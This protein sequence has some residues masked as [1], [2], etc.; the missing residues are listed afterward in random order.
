[1]KL[2]AI[3]LIILI[4][5]PPATQ[6]QSVAPA[7]F[8]ADTAAS[9][10]W[11]A[12]D[13]TE[14]D[15]CC[16]GWSSSFFKGVGG[17][18]YWTDHL[19]TELDISWPGTTR[20]FTYSSRPNTAESPFIYDDHTYTT[21]KVSASQ[22]YQFGQNAVVHPFVGIG[23]DV[24]HDRDE[25][26]RTTQLGRAFSEIH[27]TEHETHVRP[28]LTTG[29]KAYFSER[30]FFRTDVR[31]GFS[32][33]LD[34]IVWRSGIGV[35]FGKSPAHVLRST[36]ASTH[37]P[38]Q[39]P[40]AAVR[41]TAELWR[42]YAAKLPIGSA[43][44]VSSKGGQRILAYLMAVED[45]GVVVKP[46]GRVSEA[47]RHISFDDLAQLEL[48]EGGTSMNRAGAIAAG[49]GAAVGTF[50]LSVLTVLAMLD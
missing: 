47:A 30:T 8:R 39:E 10:G 19:K 48:H 43:V 46:R 21:L 17:G 5:N 1:M 18:Y 13:R 38:T 4:A 35:D 22:L 27:L 6:A 16:G 15:A 9:I 3:I 31:V 12:A 45:T 41:E 7:L 2:P 20:A 32:D 50:F 40:A 34:Q 26:T 42:S 49:V 11:F 23:L 37:A 14:P 29:I 33:Q 28:F 25:I 36:Q 44:K 24:D